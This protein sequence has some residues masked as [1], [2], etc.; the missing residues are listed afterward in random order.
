MLKIHV[1]YIMLYYK[2]IHILC[3]NLRVGHGYLGI[4]HI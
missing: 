4:R 3:I 2:Y 1:Y